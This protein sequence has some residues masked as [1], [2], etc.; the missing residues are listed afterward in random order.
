MKNPDYII[1]TIFSQL[2]THQKQI[3][4]L[5]ST[6]HYIELIKVTIEQFVKR[7]KVDSNLPLLLYDEHVLMYFWELE[8][9]ENDGRT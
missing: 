9:S 8:R 2:D 6:L 4:I 5:T 7:E 3:F 1:F